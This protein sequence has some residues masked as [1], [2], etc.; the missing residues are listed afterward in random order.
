[1][2]TFF[3]LMIRRPPRSTLFP[4]TTLFRSRPPPASL[5]LLLGVSQARSRER[6]VD[7]LGRGGRSAPAWAARRLHPLAGRSAGASR[8]PQARR[9]HPGGHGLPLPVAELSR[10]RRRGGDAESA[11]RG[12]LHL[13]VSER[14]AGRANVRRGL[15]GWSARPR[16]VAPLRTPRPVHASLLGRA[17]PERDARG[18][19]GARPP[20]PVAVVPR[21]LR[22]LLPLHALPAH[23]RGATALVRLLIEPRTVRRGGR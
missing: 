22:R 17:M 7:P 21:R 19:R 11:H 20:L 9:R 12:R 10:G 15:R 5:R 6:R 3:F 14:Q 23:A 4:Y 13:W 8:A 18:D 1:M 2:S 16:A